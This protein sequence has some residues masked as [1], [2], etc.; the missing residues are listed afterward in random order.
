MLMSGGESIDKRTRLGQ[1]FTPRPVADLMVDI[2]QSDPGVDVLDP[3]SGAGVFV[4]ALEGAGYEDVEAV[5]IDPEICSDSDYPVRNEDFLK[6]SADETYDVIIGNPPYVRWKNM[7]EET[8]AFLQ[9]GFWSEKLNGLADLTYAFI[10]WCV[11]KLRPGGELVFITPFFWAQAMHAAGVREHLRTNGS[12]DTFVHF[13]EFQVF[14][15]AATNAAVFRFVKDDLDEIDVVEVERPDGNVA[16]LVSDVRTCLNAFESN[17]ECNVPDIDCFNLPQ[18]DHDDPWDFVP[19]ER[20]RELERMKDACR[21]EFPTVPVTIDGHSHSVPLNRTYASSQLPEDPD[22]RLLEGTV[23]DRTAH[24]PETSIN[25]TLDSFMET[26]ATADTDL[27]LKYTH[28]ED[29]CHISVGMV[30]GY[31]EAFRLDREEYKALPEPERDAT[32]RVVKGEHTDRYVVSNTVPFIHAPHVRSEN[33]LAERYPTIHDLLSPYRDRLA[34]RYD[35]GKDLAWFHWAFP[36]NREYFE[37]HPGPK[38]FVPSKD[39][40]PYSRYCYVDNSVYGTQDTVSLAFRQELELQEDLKY[41]VALLNSGVI[42]AWYDEKGI[43]RGH[44]TQYSKEPMSDIPV[45]LIDWDD[46]AEVDVH[47]TIVELVDE[48]L[49]ADADADTE[50]VHERIGELVRDLYGTTISRNASR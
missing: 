36:R 24:V 23:G 34:E 41:L 6:T 38:L 18:Y 8:Q 13:G 10:I 28:L 46:P 19:P 3:C 22:R 11:E 9:S 5:E 26:G 32:I 29:V 25:S 44:V 1:Y 49:A 4:R 37:S 31:E 2:V 35:Y 20:Y 33:E 40:T 43:Q 15:G 7:D 50:G 42:D 39:R 16:D 12:I 21:T 17:L 48:I 30:T 27:P 14:E 45:R 47:D